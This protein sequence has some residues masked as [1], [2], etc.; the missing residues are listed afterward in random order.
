MSGNRQLGAEVIDFLSRRR[1]FSAAGNFSLEMVPLKYNR[2][3]KFASRPRHKPLTAVIFLDILLVGLI[4]LVFAFFHHVLPA[5][6]NESQRQQE[7]LWETTA[8]T[9]PTVR[10]TAAPTQPP[11]TQAPAT[12]PPETE[13]PETTEP[14]NRTEW[15]KKFEDHFTDEVVVTDNSYTSPEVSITVE[16]IT[17]GEGNSKVTYHVAD[18]YV[19][20]MDNFTTYTANNEMRYFGTQDVMKMVE[21]SDAIIAI[22]GDFLTY[23]KSGFLMRN[24]EVYLEDSSLASICVLYEDGTMETYDGGTYKI[25]EIKARG[26][27]QVWSFGPVLL[28]GEGRVRDSYNV[29]TTVSYV[30]PRSAIGYYEPGHYCFV[31]VDGRQTGYSAGMKIPELAR[32]FEELGC[33][34]AYNLDGGGSAVMVFDAERYSK[35]SNSGDRKLG[36][37]LLITEAGYGKQ[38]DE[39]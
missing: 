14:D 36:D 22:S 38:E 23:Q 21:E 24:G 32:V 7:L 15:Q 9:E 10:E 1:G 30:N 17:Y 3:G 26:A 12:E 18:I 27:V 20:S 4:L 31:V 2:K 8:Q 25:D 35:Q 6:L 33:T 5:I 19:A 16:T 29:S 28:D 13:V 39:A 11:E 37:I 34:S